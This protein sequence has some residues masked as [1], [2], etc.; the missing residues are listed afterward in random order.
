MKHSLKALVASFVAGATVAGAGGAVIYASQ[1][2]AR[3]QAFNE[4]T[5]IWYVVGAKTADQLQW[6]R[7][8][9]VRYV[10]DATKSVGANSVVLSTVISARV[11]TPLQALPFG[12]NI[13]NASEIGE[14][15]TKTS[16]GVAQLKVGALVELDDFKTKTGLVVSVKNLDWPRG[17]K[18]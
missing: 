17:T 8:T 18:S 13:N 1:E 16:V 10:Y 7:V 2:P 5:R 9:G 15:V 3:N 4:A 11:C 12:C 6:G 14:T